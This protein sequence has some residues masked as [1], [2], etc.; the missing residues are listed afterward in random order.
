LDVLIIE[1]AHF[2]VL[3][4]YNCVPKGFLSMSRAWIAAHHRRRPC[5][6]GHWKRRRGWRD[7]WGADKKTRYKCK[8][9]F[10]Q[11]YAHNS[12]FHLQATGFE[13]IFGIFRLM[14]SIFL[15][16]DALCKRY[17]KWHNCLDA[18]RLIHALRTAA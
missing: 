16:E 13:A 6:A 4:S 12:I 7:A 10:R 1:S 11:V 17:E 2:I 8:A 18:K 14:R 3:F 5:R 15:R 9:H